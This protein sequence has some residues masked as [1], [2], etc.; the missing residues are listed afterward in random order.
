[1]QLDRGSHEHWIAEDHRTAASIDPVLVQ[2]SMLKGQLRS[3]VYCASHRIAFFFFVYFIY[4]FAFPTVLLFLWEWGLHR[5]RGCKRSTDRRAS[6]TPRSKL[7]VCVYGRASRVE[8]GCDGSSV[9]LAGFGGEGVGSTRR[10]LVNPKGPGR[11]RR[12][13]SSE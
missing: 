6:R 13:S 9:S 3:R 12:D 8:Y 4:L 2:D 7:P 1:M 11:V 10:S 5:V